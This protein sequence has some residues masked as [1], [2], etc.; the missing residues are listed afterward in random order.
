MTAESEDEIKLRR[1]LQSKLRILDN[2]VDLEEYSAKKTGYHSVMRSNTPRQE[3]EEHV[4]Y[5]NRGGARIVKKS[6]CRE[7]RRKRFY[8]NEHKSA[9]SR[10]C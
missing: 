10:Y 8:S 2:F 5:I 9:V 3:M 6:F 1:T 7:K 4:D